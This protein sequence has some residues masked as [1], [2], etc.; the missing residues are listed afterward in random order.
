MLGKAESV[1]WVQSLWAGADV[2]IEA[3]HRL[4]AER[5]AQAER[6][7][8]LMREREAK[9]A[10][11]READRIL[12]D[13][14]AKVRSM[15]KRDLTELGRYAHPPPLVQLC[16]TATCDL[17]GFGENLEYGLLKKLLV[18]ENFPKKMG[19]FDPTTITQKELDR[20][21]KLY[22]TLPEFTVKHMKNASLVCGILANW[23][24]SLR[25]VCKF[26]RD[27][28]VQEL[29]K[30]LAELQ[31]NSF[32]SLGNLHSMSEDG[33]GNGGETTKSGEFVLTK[34]G[35][36]FGDV[37]AEYC[38]MQI[39]NWSRQAHEMKTRQ[40]EKIWSVQATSRKYRRIKDH[41][42][43]ILGGSGNIGLVISNLLHGFGC[44]MHGLANK[45]RTDLPEEKVTWF[46]AD[47]EE[48]LPF[49]QSGLSVLINCLPSTP[50]TAGF[51]SHD[52]L[53][54][55]Y[56]SES[57]CSPPLFINVGRGNVISSSDLVA[58]LEQGLFSGAALDVFEE[59]PLPV[60]S[61]LWACKVGESESENSV[62]ITPHVAGTSESVVPEIVALCKKNL[63]AFTNKEELSF[64]VDVARGY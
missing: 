3:V 62:I 46:A 36:C 27:V 12:A 56:G 4:R 41:V 8:E 49:L 52:L 48:L 55:A 20:L 63:L 25:T 64:V 58:V 14:N 19:N 54:E 42:V 61:P 21:D 34:I 32:T 30:E 28:G 50:D 40:N 24:L 38:L 18:K 37:I 2:I 17:L 5:A 11:V 13:A 29:R 51:L 44:Q 59:E 31:M 22:L 60:D 7:S 1:Q 35:D 53:D 23:L 10:K 57:S 33:D 16:L 47:S 15:K 39:L 45:A 6:N 26:C 9:L 43:G